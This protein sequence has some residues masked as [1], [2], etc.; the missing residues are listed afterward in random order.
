M[1]AHILSFFFSL[2]PSFSFSLSLQKIFVATTMR[3]THST[4]HTKWRRLVEKDESC[5]FSLA[6][7]YLLIQEKRQSVQT[8][9]LSRMERSKAAVRV[10]LSEWISWARKKICFQQESGSQLFLS[11]SESMNIFQLF[12][13]PTNCRQLCKLYFA[14]F[15]ICEKFYTMYVLSFAENIISE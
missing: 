6:L 12:W 10:I 1:F 5:A 2:S 15:A 14:F 3:I 8:V 11:P 13:L 7:Q 4:L 9:L